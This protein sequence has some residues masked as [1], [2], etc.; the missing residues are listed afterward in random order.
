M[1]GRRL[2]SVSEGRKSFVTP[3]WFT[4]R[5]DGQRVY[6]WVQPAIH[7]AFLF[8]LTRFLPPPPHLPKLSVLAF[9]LF[10]YHIYICIVKHMHTRLKVPWSHVLKNI[11][12]I[13]MIVLPASFL[14]H[15]L[16]L[17]PFY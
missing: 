14:T 5:G 9:D 12:R 15:T 11:Y 16:P 17:L 7:F 6:R 4:N 3:L 1:R 2:R 13:K 10:T 8:A